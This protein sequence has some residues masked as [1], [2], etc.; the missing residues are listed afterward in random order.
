MCVRG[1][2]PPIPGVC[3][4]TATPSSPVRTRFKLSAHGGRTSATARRRCAAAAGALAAPVRRG[5]TGFGASEFRQRC[6][7]SSR[8]LADSV[9]S[10]GSRSLTEAPSRVPTCDAARTTE[11]AALP[12]AASAAASECAHE[13]RRRHNCAHPNASTPSSFTIEGSRFSHEHLNYH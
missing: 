7:G 11:A 5:S 4:G 2:S 3:H 13:S 9:L 10:P 12:V 8:S 6:W 1:A